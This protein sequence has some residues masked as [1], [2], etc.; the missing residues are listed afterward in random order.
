NPYG[1]PGQDFF[2][3]DQRKAQGWKRFL[4]TRE[5]MGRISIKGDNEQFVETTSRA[6]GFIQTPAV[7]M[8]ADLF[9]EKVLKVLEKYVVHLINWR[10]P[11]KS[12]HNHT[13]SPEEVGDEVVSQFITNINANDILSIDYNPDILEKKSPLK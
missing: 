8:L 6:H 13:I 9:V 7:D 12:N 5:I 4:G 3:I 10:E 1:E 2:G 11:L